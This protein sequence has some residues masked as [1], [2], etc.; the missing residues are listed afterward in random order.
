MRSRRG[1]AGVGEQGLRER[2]GLDQVLDFGEFGGRGLVE[3]ERFGVR[4]RVCQRLEGCD[5]GAAGHDEARSE[6][7][8]CEG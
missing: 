7:K 4:R 8:E 2:V 1:V 6:G 3:R 5:C